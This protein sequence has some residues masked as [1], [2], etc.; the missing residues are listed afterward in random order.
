VAYLADHSLR[1]FGW[2]RLGVGAVAGILLLTN[3]L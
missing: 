3:V 1:M 2:Y